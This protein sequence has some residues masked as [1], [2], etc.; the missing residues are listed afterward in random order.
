MTMTSMEHKRNTKNIYILRTSWLVLFADSLSQ[1]GLELLKVT[2]IL[3]NIL[4]FSVQLKV[5]VWKIYY[6]II[7]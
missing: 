7:Y 6:I 5:L 2:S 1:W 4:F 3:Q